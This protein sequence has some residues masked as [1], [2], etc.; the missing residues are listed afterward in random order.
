MKR[1]RFLFLAV[2]AAVLMLTGCE[3]NELP[4]G[5]GT[6]I[7]EISSPK[8]DSEIEVFPYG[9]SDYSDPIASQAFKKG[10]SRTVEFVLN[11]GNYVVECGGAVQ[12]SD[13]SA[14]AMV[15]IQVG[16]THTLKFIGK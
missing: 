14:S 12:T 7:V 11:A 8:Y 6:L 3:K 5:T 15:Q 1:L 13:G 9:M 10:S 16:Q 2:F 4:A